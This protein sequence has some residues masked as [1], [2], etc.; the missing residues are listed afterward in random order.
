MLGI[1]QAPQRDNAARPCSSGGEARSQAPASILRPFTL[2]QSQESINV[3]LLR[4]AKCVTKDFYFIYEQRP[5]L[6]FAIYINSGWNS[7][8]GHIATCCNNLQRINTM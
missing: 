1:S 3:A 2:F 4:C 7:G 6:K 5:V 8:W